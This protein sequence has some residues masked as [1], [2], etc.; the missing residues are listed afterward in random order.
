MRAP[1]G[2]TVIRSLRSWP[3]GRPKPSGLSAG[4]QT[5][6]YTPS[7]FP[8][9]PRKKRV[10]QHQR[11]GPTR[12]QANGNANVVHSN[13]LSRGLQLRCLNVVGLRRQVCR[14]RISNF[15]KANPCTKRA[16]SPARRAVQRPQMQRPPVA[17]AS[18][19]FINMLSKRTNRVTLSGS[20]PN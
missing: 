8:L 13:Y 6:L 20:P 2:I 18:Q 14:G 17:M 7:R 10:A 12:R 4:L 19:T 1:P 16:A 15:P 9:N 5:I 11:G 3:T